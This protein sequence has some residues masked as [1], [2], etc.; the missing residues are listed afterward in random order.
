VEISVKSRLDEIIRDLDAHPETV[1]KAAAMALNR[2][3]PTARSR[4][5][6]KINAETGLR[7]SSIRKR[8]T[9]TKAR[10]Y[11]LQVKLTAQRHAPNI[12]S[13]GGVQTKQGVRSR[14]WRKSR[15]YP[16][17]FILPGTRIAVARKTKARYPL[18]A[19]YGP[20]LPNAFVTRVV[21]EEMDKAVHERF[22]IEFMRALRSLWRKAGVQ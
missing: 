14:A 11:L 18:K 2:V 17:T 19:I 8:I 20:S 22:P 6:K 13:Y 7:Q 21:T 9:L 16:R 4:A 3:A 10:D 15:V 1:R 5:V 12:A